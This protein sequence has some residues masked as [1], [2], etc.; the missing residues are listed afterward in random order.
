M[1]YTGKMITL[2]VNL[3]ILGVDKGQQEEKNDLCRLYIF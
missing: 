2:A 3:I 1:K